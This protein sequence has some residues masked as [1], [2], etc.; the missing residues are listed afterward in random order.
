MQ[1]GT[2]YSRSS[3]ILKWT[4][5]KD[6]RAVGSYQLQFV[7]GP[8]ASFTSAKGVAGYF[9]VDVGNTEVLL[10]EGLTRE[11]RYHARLRAR[12]LSGRA[13]PWSATKSFTLP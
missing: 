9:N 6:N 3:I 10:I 4:L 7:R 12:D 8:S 13:G 2:Y 11:Q 5:A 1:V